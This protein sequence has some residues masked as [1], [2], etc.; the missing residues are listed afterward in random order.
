MNSV[1]DPS[2]PE[3]CERSRARATLVQVRSDTLDVARILMR[4]YADSLA[5]DLA[6]QGFDQELAGL[7]GDY[8]NPRGTLLIAWAGG[9][10]A[11]LCALRALD[12]PEPSDAAEM[13]RLYVRP[14]HRHGGIGRQLALAII[15]EAIARGYR[16]LML[17]T[18]EAMASA[19]RLYEGLGFVPIEPY[20]LPAH[21]LA[22]HYRLA[23]EQPEQP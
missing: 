14:K 10:P 4:E 3:N 8:A 23:L 19:Q 21:P 2:Q 13:K 15:G 9:E 16:Y 20:R 5:I 6:Y 7:P 12:L 1:R 17:D 11:G 18:L 22:R